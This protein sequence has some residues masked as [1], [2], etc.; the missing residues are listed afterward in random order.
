MVE[1]RALWLNESVH[2][3]FVIDLKN[4]ANSEPYRDRMVSTLKVKIPRCVGAEIEAVLEIEI[5]S[6]AR[7][8]IAVAFAEDVTVTQ[9]R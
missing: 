9:V 8:I 5:E 4:L 7:D 6:S 2:G 3:Y 1:H